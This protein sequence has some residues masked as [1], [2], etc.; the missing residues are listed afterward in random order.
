LHAA[1]GL[2][3]T[4]GATLPTTTW[5]AGGGV[6]GGGGGQHDDD[7]LDGGD[8]E[9]QLYLSGAAVPVTTIALP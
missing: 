3:T 2:R 9:R 4:V 6:G 7:T 8:T 1:H 5:T